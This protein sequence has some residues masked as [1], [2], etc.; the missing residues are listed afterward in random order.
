[1][2]LTH[3]PKFLKGCEKMKTIL[4]AGAG[5][6]GLIAAAKL[7]DAGYDV[8]VLE[9]GGEGTLGHDWEDGFSFSVLANA[10]GIKTEDLP[11]DFWRP[12]GDGAFLSPSKREKIVVHY[13][14]TG[15]R[16]V[17][18]K[19][20]INMLLDH[21]VKHGVEIRYGVKV[22]GPAVE[23]DR[24]EGVITSEGKIDADL[25]IDAAGAFSPVRTGL[26]DLFG[27][28]KMPKNGDV[29]YAHRGYYSKAYEYQPDI[30]FEV[31]L[32]HEKEQGL[33]WFDTSSEGCDV[34]IGR[35]FP[36][37]PEKVEEQHE[38]FRKD[39]PWFGTELLHGGGYAIIPVRR[40]LPLM[41]A[42]GYAAV[43]DS[44]FMTTPMNGMGIDL[45]LLAGG[46]LA[47]TVI[48][49]NS[50]AAKDLWKYN[51]AYH[52]LYGAN[53]ARNHGLKGAL[54]ALPY[55][56]IDFFFENGI[57]Q[58]ADLQGAGDNTSF[59]VLMQKFMR[60][61]KHPRWFFTLLGGLMKGTAA[62]KLYRKPPEE[63][64]LSEILEWSGKIE[65]KDVEVEIRN[66]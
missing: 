6:G 43:G 26:P 23:N 39:H 20:L 30:G 55:E 48:K 17:W 42:N 56:A 59:P 50:S 4:I 64:S 51:R 54:L 44:A 63:F 36:L 14:P 37:T 57:I 3:I 65:S 41:V 35:V 62:A 49:Y 45:S 16:V 60:G 9:K 8:T 22:Y 33:S 19:T 38:L 7:A 5:H 10:L 11:S 18:R 46:I 40:P 32:Y 1:M 12:R 31:Y 58:S 15:Q 66:H 47:D 24:V 25:V 53:N 21:A 52:I 34:L 13:G 61:M 2:I 27:I 28:E 29:F